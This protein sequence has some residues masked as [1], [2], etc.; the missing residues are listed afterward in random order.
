MARGGEREGQVGEAYGNRTDL[1]MASGT[2]G[3][4]VE[5]GRIRGAGASASDVAAAT[6][7]GPPAPPS[8]VSADTVMPTAPGDLTPLD[9]PGGG[10]PMLDLEGRQSVFP[11]DPDT[12][13][14]ALYQMFGHDDVRELLERRNR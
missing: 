9:A 8:A 13:L 5:S 12:M 3:H 4:Q 2:S 6:P 7:S 10:G 14:R 11:K 1:A